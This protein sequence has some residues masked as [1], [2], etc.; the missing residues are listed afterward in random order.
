MTRTVMYLRQ[1]PIQLQQGWT[2]VGSNNT[3]NTRK[4]DMAQD[5]MSSYQVK[6][7]VIEV[8]LM[9]IGGKGFNVARS[10]K[11]F[12]AAAG[13]I[14]KEFSIIPLKNEGDNLCRAT[15]VP[16]TKDGIGKCYWHVIKFNNINGSMRI[17]TSMDIGKLKQAGSAFCMYLQKNRVYINKAQLVTEDGVT[18]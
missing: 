14:D 6:T 5:G 15:D 4:D 3:H 7:G 18:L 17:R 13:E 12:I 1:L 9:K 2:P 11:E 10:L 16:N 8:R